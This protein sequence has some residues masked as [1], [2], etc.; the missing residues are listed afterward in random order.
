MKVRHVIGFILCALMLVFAIWLDHCLIAQW[1][2]LKTPNK[3]LITVHDGIYF[4]QE[5]DTGKVVLVDWMERLPTTS[6]M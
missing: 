4:Y 3:E 5:L 6:E 1:E 2:A